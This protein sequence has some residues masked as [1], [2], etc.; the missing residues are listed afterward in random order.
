MDEKT[1]CEFS[2]PSIANVATGPS[3]NVGD[4]Y[5]ELKSS[6][7]NMV[8][9]RI[10]ESSSVKQLY[11]GKIIPKNPMTQ[12]KYKKTS[13]YILNTEEIILPLEFNDSDLDLQNILEKVLLVKYLQM[14]HSWFIHFKEGCGEIP[15]WFFNNCWM[16]AGTIPE[17]LPEEIVKIIT[18]ES[19]K[20]LKD[21][22][23]ILMQFYAE[24]SLPWIVKWD[25]VVHKSQFLARLRRRYYA[26]W[27]DKFN[28][29][30]HHQRKKEDLT[31]LVYEK[32]FK[33]LDDTP[34]PLQIKSATQEDDEELVQCSQAGPSYYL[35][36][37][38]EEESKGGGISD[39]SPIMQ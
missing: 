37:K 14:K 3:V 19:K 9:G 31:L 13:Q 27:W 8:Q 6:L 11:Q 23:F 4:V 22:P 34:H 28:I 7:I 36:L 20:D 25:L 12:E 32:M 5:F 17:I 33:M 30:N 35:P 29:K 24:T 1:L 39:Y 2:I 10:D 21:Y 15:L 18:Q 38:Q 16:K 26:Q